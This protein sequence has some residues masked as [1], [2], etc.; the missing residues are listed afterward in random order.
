M[1][2]GGWLDE[3]TELAG[4]WAVMRVVLTTQ[5]QIGVGPLSQ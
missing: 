1:A 3:D 4:L 2:T 5:I